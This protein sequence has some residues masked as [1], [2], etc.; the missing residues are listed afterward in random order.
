[1]KIADRRGFTI[2]EILIA[3]LVVAVISTVMTSMLIFGLNTFSTST[4][5]IS[6]HDLV[7]DI[8]NRIGKDIS[9][10]TAYKYY[11]DMTDT[12]PYTE[13]T[14]QFPNK[15][16]KRW[17]FQ[18]GTL[19]LA[20][21]TYDSSTDTYNEKDYPDL[22]KGLDTDKTTT[23]GGITK[24]DFISK[25]EK[26]DS[27]SSIQLTVKPTATNTNR[28]KERNVNKPIITEFSVLYK[29]VIS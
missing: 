26:F 20:I 13:L 28:Y 27:T 29:G 23:I 25:F 3:L 15:N 22:L 18:D 12:H 9:E 11:P 14:L 2:I 1:M 24:V 8:M 17:R 7:I 21:L 6:Q 10:A 4:N 5:N 16:R 19:A